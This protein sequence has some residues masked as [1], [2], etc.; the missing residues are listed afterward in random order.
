MSNVCQLC[1]KG[2]IAP[3]SAQTKCMTCPEQ[4]TTLYLGANNLESCY[5]VDGLGN[6]QTLC[7]KCPEHAVCH[8]GRFYVPK[9]FGRFEYNS[10]EIFM[11]P[12]FVGCLGTPM[13]K[14][15]IHLNKTA[16]ELCAPNF[17]RKSVREYCS[18]KIW[19]LDIVT[20][21]RRCC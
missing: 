2:Q 9:G 6:A 18:S 10:S 20:K 11:C 21:Q 12:I 13:D 1:Q 5:C 16:L 17:T 4:T 7:S 15:G 8:R 19:I 3:H 14:N